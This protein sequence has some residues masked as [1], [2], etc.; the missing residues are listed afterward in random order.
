M[1]KL[2]SKKSGAIDTLVNVG[3]G[4]AANVAID[5]AVA[6]FDALS[7]QTQTVKNAVKIAAGVIGGSM[8]KNKYLKSGLEGIAVCGVAQLVADQL[9][10]NTT[11]SGLP[12]GT[13]GRVR[14]GNRY[15]RGS[16]GV[17]GVAGAGN[18]F[19]GK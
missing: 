11:T 7:S 2:F 14:M 18:D 5:Y 1:A 4:G 12:A 6:Q 3:I 17:R 13:I 15:F 9:A 8:V 19:M 16:R 10:E